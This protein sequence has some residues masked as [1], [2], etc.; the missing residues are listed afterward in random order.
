MPA[1]ER[2][3]CPDCPAVRD[4]PM[5][6]QAP[7]ARCPTGSFSIVDMRELR[8]VITDWGGVLTQP[9]RETVRDW[10][11]A[12]QIDWDT[13]VSVVGPWLTDAADPLATAA[14][15]ATM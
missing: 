10:I 11:T 5:T 3:F 1:M 15:A 6:Y 13:Y 14:A 9:I 2:H 8:A 4:T 7:R 12:D